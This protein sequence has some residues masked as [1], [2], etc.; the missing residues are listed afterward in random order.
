MRRKNRFKIFYYIL[1]VFIILFIL[2]YLY[3]ILVDRSQSILNDNY[4]DIINYNLYVNGNGSGFS[5]KK[6]TCTLVDGKCLITLPS[7]DREDRVV[8]GYSFDKDSKNA[9][10][11]TGD[12]INL[13]KDITLYVISYKKLNLSIVKEDIDFLENDSVSCTIYNE[14]T[15]CNVSVPFY[16]KIGYEVRGYSTNTDSLT[17]FI[18]PGDNYILTK[19]LTIY[20]IYNTLTRG[21]TINVYKTFQNGKLVFDIEKGCSESVYSNYLNYFSFITEKANFLIVGSKVSFLT[22]ETYDSI[23][24]KSSVGMTYGP[25][26]LKLLDLRCSSVFLNV[27]YKTIVHELAHGWDFYYSNFNNNRS[28]SQESDIINLFNKYVND[29]NRPFR[30]YS[31]SRIGEFFA[32][33]VVYYYFKYIDPHDGYKN[34]NFPNDIKNVLEKYICISKNN[35]KNS[36]CSFY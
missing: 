14:Q 32:D 28:I 34:L 8:L 9:L 7:V 35:Y 12:V 11:T 27:S 26:S 33:M 21:T 36:K 2:L 19:S 31:Y 13:D 20:P 16:N 4:S 5:N 22:N 1:L 30:D 24:G 17:G 25:L 23:W 18:F 6:M 29:S 3:K 15:S 10:Y